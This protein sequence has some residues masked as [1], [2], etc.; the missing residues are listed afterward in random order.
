M[1]RDEARL[2]AESRED[3]RHFVKPATKGSS[4]RAVSSCSVVIRQA[5]SIPGWRV[6][7]GSPQGLASRLPRAP[8]A[9][10]RKG[11]GGEPEKRERPEH[12]GEYDRGRHGVQELV[13]ETKPIAAS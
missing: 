12:E 9:R 5:Y 2:S 11:Q 13:T 1:S 10:E 8:A 7:R 3:V 6:Q 4:P